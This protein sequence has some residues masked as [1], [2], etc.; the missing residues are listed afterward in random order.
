MG[1]LVNAS[2]RPDPGGRGD[3]SGDPA[4]VADQSER[5]IM[6]EQRL[7]VDA[8]H[9]AMAEHGHRPAP[10]VG[11]QAVE[12]GGDRVPEGV[13][14][15][16]EHGQRVG[17]ISPDDLVVDIHVLGRRVTEAT[18]VGFLKAVE[19]SRDEAEP[20]GQRLTGLDGPTHRA[21]HNGI[22]HLP[23]QELGGR[24]RLL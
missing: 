12:G 1:G 2:Q 7:E 13:V 18:V 16:V 24:L 10:V 11:H 5:V 22:D 19:P 21:G 8:D 4:V 20:V 23:G 15:V 3:N 6:A 14:S 9:R 17:Q